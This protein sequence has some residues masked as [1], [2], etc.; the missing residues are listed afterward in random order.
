MRGSNIRRSEL[1]PL[2]PSPLPVKNGER[3]KCARR[4]VT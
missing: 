4:F 3:E 2:T 1:P